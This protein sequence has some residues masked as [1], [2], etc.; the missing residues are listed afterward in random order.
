MSI[1]SLIANVIPS[2]TNPTALVKSI[3]QVSGAGHLVTCDLMIQAPADFLFNST[4]SLTLFVKS[5]SSEW[6]EFDTSDYLKVTILF[7]G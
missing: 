4:K 1:L 6:E 3:R 7:A 2:L 5:L